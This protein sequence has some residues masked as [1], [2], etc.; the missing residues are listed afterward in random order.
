VPALHLRVVSTLASWAIA[1]LLVTIGGRCLASQPPPGAAGPVSTADRLPSPAVEPPRQ[2]AA[3][4][5][6]AASAAVDSA[7]A[8]AEP[9]P[10]AR[11]LVVAEPHGVNLRAEPTTTSVVIATLPEG[12][13]VEGR[14]PDRPTEP[15]SRDWQRVVWNG[16][17]GW[18]WASLLRPVGGAP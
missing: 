8:A 3:G 1:L 9:G 15:A 4:P 6:P 10:P 18:V 12:A 14:S 2:D 11:R 13:L 16:H 7:A 5:T 17:E